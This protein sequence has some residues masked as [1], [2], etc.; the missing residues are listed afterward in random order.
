MESA[1]YLSKQIDEIILSTT[2][3]GDH[4]VI[5]QVCNA[6]IILVYWCRTEQIN[7]VLF[8]EQVCA[9][10]VAKLTS[11]VLYNFYSFLDYRQSLAFRVMK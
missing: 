6:S 7:F 9:A 11:L 2:H 3:Y 10:S 4:E 8:V 1:H 5:E